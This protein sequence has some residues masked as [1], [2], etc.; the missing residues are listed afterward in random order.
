MIV[1]WI[2]TAALAVPMGWVFYI[3]TLERTRRES[4]FALPDTTL[5]YDAFNAAMAAQK[6]GAMW[7]AVITSV[8]FGSVTVLIAMVLS[9]A[10]LAACRRPVGL[11]AR[12]HWLSLGY[13]L[14][15]FIALAIW[16]VSQLLF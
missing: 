16:A 14:V 12:L 7:E 13:A 8:M 4:E 10:H 1:R 5:G 15:P 3:L 6:A 11:S 9:A 2:L